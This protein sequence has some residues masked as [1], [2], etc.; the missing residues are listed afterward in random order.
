MI[1]N[2]FRLSGL[3]SGMD[4]EALVTKLMNAEKIPLNKVIQKK[5]MTEWK[6]DA[7]RDVNTKFLDLRS[8]MEALRLESTFQK[9]KLTS[10]D[11]AKVGVS[12]TGTP[13]RSEYVISSAKLYQPGTPSSVKFAQAGVANDKA[14]LG[15]GFSFTLNNESISFTA[16][17]TIQSSIAKINSLSA[18][19]GV[20]ATYSSG[21]NAIIFTS[22]DDQTD[23]SI[24]NVSDSSNVLKIA[25]GTV[26][27]SLN[28]FQAG[29]ASGA[30]GISPVSSTPGE[31]TI[32]GTTITIKSNQFTYD[33]IQFNLKTELP[34][35]SNV[36][37]MK[38]PDVDAIFDTIK[39]F[40][41]KYNDTIK[42]LHDKLGEKRYKDYSPLLDDQKKDMKDKEIELWEEKAKS[43]L[44]A[45][46]QKI[47]SALD[48]MR[49]ILYS[50]V[51]DKDPAKMN[52]DFDTLAEIGI[53]SSTNYRDNGKLVIDETKL[54]AA[55][56]NNLDQVA[57]LFSK[58]YD[59]GASS[60]NT[61]NNAEEFQNSGV[62][63]RLYDQLN[64]TMKDI[65]KTAG[66]SSDTY[67]S[68]ALKQ[69]DEQIDSWE[70]RLQ[71]KESYYWKQFTAME[72]AIQKSNT[73]SSW[74]MQQMG[75]GM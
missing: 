28:D 50:K 36:T 27:G 15:S 41:D 63:W 37:I 38:K 10:S 64:E 65:T 40:V 24:A 60:N 70:K 30:V 57:Q 14:E 33:G 55:L 1:S 9:S 31:V 54:K 35:G 69:L 44:L 8:S 56:E 17:D 34:A 19:T 12:L 20:T 59:T 26:S 23:I 66:Y 21:D 42:T 73:Q 46:D 4:T 25:A 48:K 22:K 67:L 45:N 13:S 62:A 43:G 16:Q 53:T 68:K 71:T 74:L 5:T 7:Y 49:S 11:D 2:D 47:A 32:N 29:N 3:A 58:K 39:G 6:M 61:V 51:S 52:S 18:K 75:G 72:Q